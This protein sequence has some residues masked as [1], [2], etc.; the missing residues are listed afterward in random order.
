M[1]L[2]TFSHSFKMGSRAP[3]ENTFLKKESK[4]SAL[5]NVSFDSLLAAVA[6]SS[7]L[8]RALIRQ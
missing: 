8:R 5:K 6:P 1:A 2:E 7:P 3:V 4:Q